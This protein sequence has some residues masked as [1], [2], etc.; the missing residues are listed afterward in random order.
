MSSD[1]SAEITA[2][3]TVALAVFALAAAILATLAFLKQSRE[4]RILEQQMQ[5][6]Q[7]LLAREALERHRAQAARVFI[8]S[9]LNNQ[10]LWVPSVVN[11]SNLPVYD[12]RLWYYD[13]FP[14]RKIRHDIGVVLPGETRSLVDAQGTGD[15]S[16]PADM[17]VVLIFRDAAGA[18]WMRQRDGTLTEHPPG[19]PDKAASAAIDALVTGRDF[20]KARTT[21]QP[22][23]T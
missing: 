3:A 15:I 20:R 14:D 22:P 17:E 11:S 16:N 1:L 23:V 13:L 4:V 9:T 19:E 6:Q 7:G 21:T 10:D 2:I 5:T 12:A 8:G 18:T